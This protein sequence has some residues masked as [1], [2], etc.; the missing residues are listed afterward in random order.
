MNFIIKKTVEKIFNLK[1]IIS[2]KTKKSIGLSFNIL[3]FCSIICTILGIS[4]RDLYFV[5]SFSILGKI[6]FVMIIFLF[7]SLIVYI[8][9]KYI[10]NNKIEI[11]I[12]G[13]RVDI[14]YGDIFNEKGIIVI[15][16]DTT[17]STQ[18]DNIKISKN[19]LHGQLVLK[20]GDQNEI[21]N[22]V[23][24]EA[25]KNNIKK[26]NGK[27]EFELG[28]VV[29]YYNKKNKKTYLM[30]A[31]MQLDLDNRA[32]TDIAQYEKMLIKMWN[33][34]DKKYAG[35]EISIPLLGS[36]ISRFKDK[37]KD[38]IILLK[39]ILYTLYISNVHINS[40]IN[41]VLYKDTTYID[42]YENINFLKI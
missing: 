18:V 13:T 22:S 34:I 8:I 4:L 14:K 17:F 20:H 3:G 21:N 9:I 16:C 29:K 32:S 7:L 41:I 10:C 37:E 42:L 23:V 35:E 19:S 1:N 31:I 39:I 15:G 5:N 12:N 25:K 27:Y 40:K 38:N 6:L 11:T 28:S 36:G 33:E 24:D 2:N 30:A 26:I